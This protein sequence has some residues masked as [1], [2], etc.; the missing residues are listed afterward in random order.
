[1]ELYLERDEIAEFGL[2]H[3]GRWRG[4]RRAHA[5]AWYRRATKLEPIRKAATR[6]ESSFVAAHVQLYIPRLLASF[7]AL[8]TLFEWARRTFSEDLKLAVRMAGP[9]PQ[10]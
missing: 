1:M 5:E 4:A 9:K 3:S 6:H 7:M 2:R 8:A 10:A